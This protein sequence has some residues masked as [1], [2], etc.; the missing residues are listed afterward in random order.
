[1]LSGTCGGLGRFVAFML[2]S[3]GVPS[4]SI[5][6]CAYGASL[7]I[8][9]IEP[10]LSP[11][12]TAPAVFPDQLQTSLF[13]PRISCVFSF[14]QGCFLVSFRS[15]LKFL[16]IGF[17][18]FL[19]SMFLVILLCVTNICRF[20]SLLISTNWLFVRMNIIDLCMLVFY[21]TTLP[22]IIFVSIFN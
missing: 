12:K 15:V 11:L 9:K 6:I 20:F 21:G 10:D 14:V 8:T 22:N 13:Y 4:Y 2:S 16:H 7:S 1:M 19:L 18:R 5:C 3:P 17:A